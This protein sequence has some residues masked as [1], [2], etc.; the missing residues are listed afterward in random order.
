MLE[1]GKEGKLKGTYLYML[2][3]HIYK[4]YQYQGEGIMAW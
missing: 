2:D 1:T 4:W 3:I